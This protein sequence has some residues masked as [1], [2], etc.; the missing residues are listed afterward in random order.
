MQTTRINNSR[1]L[2]VKDRKFSVYCFYMK[3]EYILKFSNCISVPLTRKY[4]NKRM[5]EIIVIDHL[6]WNALIT[7]LSFLF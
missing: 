6:K 1:I 2:W 3:P 4:F 7:F 5:T